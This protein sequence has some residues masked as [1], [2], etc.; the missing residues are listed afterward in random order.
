MS[1][2]GM[3]AVDTEAIEAETGLMIYEPQC[4]LCQI[5]RGYPDVA[6]VLYDMRF[7]RGDSYKR[8]AEYLN[9]VIVERSLPYKTVFVS[10]VH[11]H[12]LNHTPLEKTLVHEL[13]TRAFPKV[14]QRVNGNTE[15]LSRVLATKRDNYDKL[16]Q[17]FE[18]WQAIFDTLF[19]K[20]GVSGGPDTL[21][22]TAEDVRT[23]K[24]ATLGI[25]VVVGAMD[26]F[27]RDRDFVMEVMNFA[28]DLYATQTAQRL[29]EGLAEIKKALTDRDIA[30][31]KTLAWY[32]SE[33]RQM[34]LRVVDGL[35]EECKT[36]TVQNFNL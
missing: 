13:Q 23:L 3:Q 12:F 25:G 11:G 30:D 22:L 7:Q 9:T 31:P 21:K 19:E 4:K 32:D 15:V 5:T 20:T 26:K 34:L 6:V 2:R 27:I 33:I 1:R 24:E 16:Q 36:A 35:Y 18:N 14:I 29:G 10:N 8:L 28:I 17:N